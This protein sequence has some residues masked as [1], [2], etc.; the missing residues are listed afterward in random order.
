MTKV[1]YGEAFEAELKAYLDAL[2]DDI[3]VASITHLL[4]YPTVYV[5]TSKSGTGKND[6]HLVYVG[7]TTNILKRTWQHIKQD[8]EKREDWK[9]FLETPGTE[10]YV[11][12]H[13][14][15]NKSL[16]LDI[17][18][19]FMLFLQ[20]CSSVKRLNNRR[21][22][23]QNQYFTSESLDEIFTDI[24]NELH[25]RE[26]NLFES[27]EEIKASAVYKASPFH[28]LTDE[29]LQAKDRILESVNT[30]LKTDEHGHQLILVHGAAGSGK[31]VLI[32]SIFTELLLGANEENERFRELNSELD[33]STPAVD[34]YLVSAHDEQR[35]VYEDIAKKSGIYDG[36]PPRV[37][38]PTTFINQFKSRAAAE[39]VLI[40]EAHLL[41]TQ[42]NQGYSGGTNQLKDIIKR[43]KVVIA[44]F[45]QHQILETTQ[46][47]EKPIE[48]ELAEYIKLEPITLTNQMRIKADT[49]TVNWI[50]TI[51]DESIIL[52]FSEDSSGYAVRIFDSPHALHDAIKKKADQEETSLSRLIA[53]Y[54]WDYRGNRVN[55]ESADGL[56]K[57]DIAHPEGRFVMPW[58][59][60][61]KQ[62]RALM[63]RNQG[64]SWPEQEQTINEVGST[65][66]IQG[67]D[68]N[69][70]GVILGPSVVYRDGRVTIDPS[71]S[72]YTKAT[73]QRTL[74]DGSKKSFAGEFL[75][76]QLNVLLTR[77]V[78]GLYIYAVDED[79][80]EALHEATARIE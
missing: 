38:K 43:A 14:Y 72:S 28:K 1:N 66:T 46:Y 57:V 19:R 51:I 40:D 16:T 36:E 78:N 31:T 75:S 15:F 23:E 11:I 62:D 70:A 71:K 49:S 50:R 37:L 77:G 47:W 73:R 42:S 53:T 27:P 17:E 56:W 30:A 12:G 18:N 61:I 3:K 45:D 65:Y 4:D 54:D 68:L 13:E 29:Q 32:S 41:L 39:V 2:D 44:V 9:A 74:S 10:L 22:N 79:L 63:R 48:E 25:F 20:A 59:R 21:T 60:E 24:W 69:Y 67:F 33:E 80:R 8:P 76:N 58:N 55:D 5:V 64:K 26:P 6:G 35:I 34:G 52:P 7:E